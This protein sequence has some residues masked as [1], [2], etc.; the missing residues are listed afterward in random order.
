MLDGLPVT[1]PYEW[2]ALA[3]L[4]PLLVI[5]PVRTL[6]KEADRVFLLRLEGELGG[7]FRKALLRSIGMQLLWI[8]VPLLILWPL[9]KHCTGAGT[10][11]LITLLVSFFLIKA[12][13]LAGSWYEDKLQYATYRTV[14]SLFRWAATALIAYMLLVA[15]WPIAGLLLLCSLAAS[16]LYM[17]GTPRFPVNWEQ[18]IQQ[19]KKISRRGCTPSSAFLRMSLPGLTG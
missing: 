6:L 18:L 16:A 12:S 4:I 7:Y 1:Y 15:S 14:H 5:S 19:E 17:R 8:G 3:V 11:Y 9:I 13:N 10:S 2:I